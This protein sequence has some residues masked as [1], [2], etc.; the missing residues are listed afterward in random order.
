[1]KQHHFLG[2]LF[3]KR[4]H[5]PGFREI[6]NISGP[7]VVKVWAKGEKRNDSIRNIRCSHCGG[8]VAQVRNRSVSGA[9]CSDCLVRAR[10]AGV[11][12]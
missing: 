9:T 4:K 10:L 5:G 1:M 2:I 7:K 6:S 11:Q 12:A 3:Q 8:V